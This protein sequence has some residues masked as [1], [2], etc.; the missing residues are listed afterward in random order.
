MNACRLNFPA[1]SE[2]T[3][4]IVMPS[5]DGAESGKKKCYY[6]AVLTDEC[7]RCWVASDAMPGHV[8]RAVSDTSSALGAVFASDAESVAGRKD[9][10]V[11]AAACPFHCLQ[12]DSLDQLGKRMTE[13]EQALFSL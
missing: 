2:K 7:Q 4:L 6:I 1:G 11:C 12:F 8:T 3:G 9:I 5:A 10:P 13:K